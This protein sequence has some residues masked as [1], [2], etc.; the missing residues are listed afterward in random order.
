MTFILYIPLFIIFQLVGEKL[1]ATLDLAIPGATIGMVLLLAFLF[2][3]P[4]NK[5]ITRAAQKLLLHLPLFFIPAGVG[6]MQYTDV[7]QQNSL[8]LFV[9]VVASTILCFIFSAW[10]TQ[11]LVRPEKN[12]TT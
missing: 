6:V 3:I 11:G 4:Q 10:L 1:K 7:L 12:I 5:N 2:I 8:A 9:S